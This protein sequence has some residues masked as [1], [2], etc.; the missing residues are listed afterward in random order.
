MSPE[1]S[2]KIHELYEAALERPVE[3]REAFL[4]RACAGDEEAR[5]RVEVMLAAN[6]QG[7]RLA[8]R[9]AHGAALT[10]VSS[11]PHADET[12]SFSS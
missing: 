3:E 8:E 2:Q 12:Q 1:S 10:F 6:A 11:T 7:D 5:R 9:S 4:A